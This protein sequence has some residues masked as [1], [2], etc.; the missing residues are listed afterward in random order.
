MNI[1]G[2][3]IKFAVFYFVFSFNSFATG[4]DSSIKLTQYAYPPKYILQNAGVDGDKRAVQGLAWDTSG[5]WFYVLQAHGD[6]SN[7]YGV[8]NRFSQGEKIFRIAQ[9]AQL[10]TKVIGHQGISPSPWAGFDLL[11]TTG[12]AVKDFGLYITALHYNPNEEVNTFK[13]IKVFPDEYSGVNYTMPAISPT[14]KKLLVLGRGEKKRVARIYN[15]ESPATPDGELY[16]H[17]TFTEWTISPALTAGKN[18]PLQADALSEN[19]I[20]LLSGYISPDQSKRLYVYDVEG[21]V[22]NKVNI[23]LVSK[24]YKKFE[25]EGLSVNVKD[26]SVLIL[27]NVEK[28]DRAK[29]SH[30]YSV[31]SATLE[32]ERDIY[33]K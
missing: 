30:I 19:R 17:A 26:D 23:H 31:P 28:K 3:S 10:P 14:K 22:I 12:P 29:M 2:V 15:L 13:F 6:K 11:T 1:I 18:Y 9:D 16:Q 32:N 20:Y 21:V 33:L 5:A 8:I 7:P 25:P 27:I 24:G 4:F